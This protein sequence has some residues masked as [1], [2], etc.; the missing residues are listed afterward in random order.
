MPSEVQLRAKL[1]R[2]QG[3]IL[4]LTERAPRAPTGWVPPKQAGLGHPCNRC[5]R[6]QP[7]GQS[8]EAIRLYRLKEP[9]SVLYVRADGTIRAHASGC[10]ALPHGPGK[11]DRAPDAPG[12]DPKANAGLMGRSGT[13]E[14]AEVW[15]NRDR[16][17]VPLYR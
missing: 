11:P 9:T 4:A 12:R 6:A 2:I 7:S 17:P 16:A 8:P 13:P 10:D 14:P 15:A 3:E 1:K 5:G